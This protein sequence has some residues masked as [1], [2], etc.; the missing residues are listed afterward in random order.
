MTTTDTIKTIDGV[1]DTAGQAAM[2]LAAL[3]PEGMV[4][5]AAVETGLSV[6][7]F[8]CNLFVHHPPPPP[9]SPGK[10]LN[11]DLSNKLIQLKGLMNAINGQISDLSSVLKS[12]T[13]DVTS[14]EA[15][16]DLYQSCQ[17]VLNLDSE[18]GLKA[19]RSSLLLIADNDQSDPDERLLGLGY[20]ASTTGI[21]ISCLLIMA[22]NDYARKDSFIPADQYWLSDKVNLLD[23]EAQTSAQ[24]LRDLM[25]SIHGQH[26]ACV[27]EPTEY[28]KALMWRYNWE[29][30]DPHHGDLLPGVEY[31]QD[32]PQAKIGNQ[33][34]SEHYQ[35][36][37]ERQAQYLGRLTQALV[38]R[39]IQLETMATYW[40]T[41]RRQ[42]L[43][44]RK[45]NS[46][47]YDRTHPKNDA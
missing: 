38:P 1:L 45:K 30:R 20:W 7:R 46:A 8:V 44:I 17:A 12:S 31:H 21:L 27:T 13:S 39:M 19:L 10:L 40:E 5:A 29:D 6:V 35:Q 32:H 9:P 34:R 11:D 24:N 47:I 25:K 43:E 42:L 3:G 36:I 26:L 37:V 41:I 28:T 18:N 33:H 22:N 4:A 15:Q 2:A 14:R 16:N 23:I